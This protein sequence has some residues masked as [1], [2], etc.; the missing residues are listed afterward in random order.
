MDIQCEIIGTMSKILVQ[1]LQTTPH[2]VEGVLKSSQWWSYFYCI[3]GLGLAFFSWLLENNFV[4]HRLLII[5]L[6]IAMSENMTMS[7]GWFANMNPFNF[8]T[9]HDL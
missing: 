4:F 5:Q 6:L 3:Y 7:F 2:K 9:Y 1:K 8:I